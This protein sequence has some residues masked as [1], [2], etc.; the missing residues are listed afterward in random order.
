MFENVLIEIL[1]FVL[2]SMCVKFKKK[3][4]QEI[5]LTGLTPLEVEF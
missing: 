4:Y 2:Q 5:T 1:L 3:L